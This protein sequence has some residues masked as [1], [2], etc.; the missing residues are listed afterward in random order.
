M[1]HQD[2]KKSNH[3][4]STDPVYRC[5]STLGISGL[6]KSTLVAISMVTLAV[7]GGTG[8][9]GKTIVETLVRNSQHQIIVLTRSVSHH[10]NLSDGLTV[11]LSHRFIQ[12]PRSDHALDRTRQVQVD[13]D[14]I[15][16]LVQ[17]LQQHAIHTIISA[18]GIFD[19]A[20]SRS[21]LNLIQ[22]AE[23]SS[24]TKRFVPSEFSFIQTKE[25]FP[26]AKSGG[27]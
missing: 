20:T 9:V 26:L 19:D 4:G 17:V 23:K 11:D 1:G 8:G 21:Q 5:L 12:E 14:D 15:P 3:H 16:S 2:A 13:Y 24:V 10:G 22:A 7:A 6:N 25:Y 18:I 27:R